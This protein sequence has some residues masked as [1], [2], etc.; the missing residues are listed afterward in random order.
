VEILDAYDLVK[1]Y[2]PAAEQA[3]CSH[4]T[5][6]RYVAAREAGKPCGTGRTRGRG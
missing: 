4:H 6:A 1:S 3:G 5:V 2:R